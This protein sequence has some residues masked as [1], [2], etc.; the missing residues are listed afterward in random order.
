[1]LLFVKMQRIFIPFRK[2]RE[3]KD[4]CNPRYSELLLIPIK[5]FPS[6][7]RTLYALPKYFILRKLS[8]LTDSPLYTLSQIN[9][10]ILSDNSCKHFLLLTSWSMVSCP[11]SYCNCSLVCWK[12]NCK[13]LKI[14]CDTTKRMF[15]ASNRVLTFSTGFHCNFDLH[16]LLTLHVSLH[17]KR[18][19]LV[20]FA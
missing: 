18:K 20:H 14:T 1:M 17:N 16:I 12:S 13:I 9:C 8:L 2:R 4:L 15:L 10:K 6:L 3:V 11:Y 7:L 5:S 19:F